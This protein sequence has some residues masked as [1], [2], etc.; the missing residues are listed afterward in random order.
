MTDF[1][2]L[3][4]IPDDDTSLFSSS[5]VDNLSDGTR[6]DQYMVKLIPDFSRAQAQR[7][8]DE[9]TGSSGV[10]VNG[11]PKKSSY[12]VRMGDVITFSFA[13]PK[14]MSALPEAIPL[15]ILYEDD[16]VI[17]VDKPRGM[18]VHPA[19]GSLNGTLVNALLGHTQ[20]LSSQGGPLRP[21]IVHRLDKDT[22]GLLMIARTEMSH[23]SL[24]KQIQQ[25]TAERRYK[26]IVWGKPSFRQA[27][28]DAPI[29]RD[30]VD[31]LRMAVIT[32]PTF[33]SR[34]ARTDFT[35]LESYD[36][37]FSLLEAKLHT[38]RTHQIR[39][40]AE[41]M[42]YP[43]VGDTLYGGIQKIASH[44]PAQKRV[45]LQSAIERLEGQALHAYSLEFDHPVTGERM[46]FKS[47]LPECFEKLI[48]SL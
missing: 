33:K 37:G 46:M 6:L 16:T 3:V 31:R 44:I 36:S 34:A 27:T 14:E 13:E 10:W 43:V 11:K 12:K 25:R 47:P 22:G 32:D 17:V 28:V 29:G 7:L 4:D 2:D 35:V 8:I 42:H 38:G 23:R 30:P 24:Q 41:Y 18:V 20:L 19:P 26:L 39:V 48:S 40:H 5:I 9:P 1:D 45:L 21:G 15:D